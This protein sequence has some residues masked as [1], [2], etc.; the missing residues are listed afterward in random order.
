M[1]KVFGYWVGAAGVLPKSPKPEKGYVGAAGFGGPPP[2]AFANGSALSSV[3][4]VGANISVDPKGFWDG[5][6]ANKSAEPN[7]LESQACAAAGF[8]E[9]GLF[10]FMGFDF[11]SGMPPNKSAPAK[12]SFAG[13]Y[14]STTG[15][16][17]ADTKGSAVKAVCSCAGVFTAENRS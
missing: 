15:L 6:G 16:E 13:C 14:T 4:V 11:F 9:G 17:G 1:S 12:R 8:V 2:K 5:A 7:G 3:L 10:R